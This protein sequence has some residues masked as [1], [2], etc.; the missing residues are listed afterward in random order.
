M[1]KFFSTIIIFF[2]FVFSIS[3][4]EGMW[5]LNQIDKLD[6]NNKGL[7][8]DVSDVYNPEKPSL[9]NAIIQVG[10]GTGSFVSSDGLI[11][12][13]H[14]VAYSGLQ[15][16]SGKDNDYIT[17]GFLARNRSDE[18]QA[19][20]Y[21]AR[22]LVEMKDVT[23]QVLDA[24]KGVTDAGDRSDKI[25]KKS[26]EISDAAT[27]GNDDLNANV[28][29]LYEGRQYILFVYKIIKDIRIVYAPPLSI[30]NYGGET[31]NWMWPRHTGD[32]TY[33]RAYVSPDGKCSEYSPNNVPY[34]PK[35]W[36]KVAKD[37][38]K[39]G[40]FTFIMGYP[41]FTTRYRS[42]NSVSWNLNEN[43]PFSI[44]NYREVINLLEETT[45]NSPEGKIRVANQIKGLANVMKNFQGKMDG[46]K[47]TN[48][49]QKKYDFENEFMKWVNSDATR[50]EKYGDILKNEK[51]L[52]MNLL[53]KTKKRDQVFGLFQGLGGT[54]IA[55]VTYIYSIANQLAKPES[56]RLP[57]Y[58]DKNIEQF[59]NNM[60]YIY[61]NYFEPSDKALFVRALKM[62]NELPE[63]QRIKGL[64]YIFSDKSQTIE[65]FVDNA[66]N[67]SKFNDVEYAKSLV[68]KSVKELE[69]LNDPFFKMA[70]SLYPESE[71]IR[72]NYQNFADNVTY[73]RKF[74]VEALFEWKGKGLYPDA[75]NTM[76]L[77]YG[78]V[79]GYEPADAVLYFPFTTLKGV[80]AKNK[81]EEPFN[82]P[83]DLINLYNNKDFGKWIN[84]KLNDVPV[85]FTHLGDITGGN[86]GS[87]VMNAKGELIGLAFDG[88]YEA[89]ISDWQYDYDLQRVIS[90]DIHYVLFITEKFAKAGFLL[91]EMGV[92]K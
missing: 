14:H 91:D 90:V 74:Y 64:E 12:T 42:S 41:G 89:M 4:Q 61:L 17:N 23:S 55:T 39:D 86:S 29:E 7:Q 34:K 78:N 77:T 87:P 82:A 49:L 31:D 36:L 85:A 73:L 10:G 52:Y 35:V 54:Q 62:A 44:K 53:D 45:K 18:I 79:K 63:G 72:I 19:I 68:G 13:N 71:A 20:G 51:D 11:L 8:L 3:A 69:E 30:G 22:L 40:D 56:E 70:A 33:M 28:T 5:L 9:Y 37:F 6:L 75:N 88:N 80:I 21:R 76:R 65:Q 27:K 16:A 92:N 59:K 47:K 48:F 15:R 26:T 58:E 67:N 38:L 50:K 32:F 25:T 81:D 84:P 60:Q 46:M 1:K 2:L 83:Q 24:V 43:Y 66:Y 57:G